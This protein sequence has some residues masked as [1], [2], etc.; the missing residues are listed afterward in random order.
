MFTAL[1]IFL[2]A[3]LALPV[4]LIVLVLIVAAFVAVQMKRYVKFVSDMPCPN[5]AKPFG[6]DAVNTA[7]KLERERA[8]QL[9][10]EH[11]N[12][13]LRIMSEWQ[14]HCP[15]CGAVFFFQPTNRIPKRQSRFAS[16]AG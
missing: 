7:R 8:A 16:R 5:C 4:L 14:V 15:D 6:L 9:R 12:V 3:L 1:Q 10:K 11:P 13:R 2:W